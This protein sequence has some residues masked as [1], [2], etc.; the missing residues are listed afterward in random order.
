MSVSLKV[1]TVIPARFA[2]QRL[3][4]KP[5]A[6]ILGKPM[7]QHV[8]ERAAGAR[9]ILM[10]GVATDDARIARAVEGFGGKVW[11]TSPD[12]QS[13]TDR[14]A[15]VARL[16]PEIDIFV[17]V[18]GDEPLMDPAAIGG[19]AVEGVGH[20]HIY[21]DSN[22]IDA[23]A[24]LDYTLLGLTGGPH[25]IEVRLANNDHSELGV[26]DSLTIEMISP[27]IQI[28]APQSGS[29][30]PG[31]SVE[32]QLQIGD[33]TLDPIGS[34]NATGHGHY[35]IEVDGAYYDLGNDPTTAYATRLS[36]GNH[37]V[38]VRLV[39]NDHLPVQEGGTCGTDNLTCS[40]IDVTVPA[41]GPYLALADYG[42]PFGSATVPV[43][44]TVTNFTLD[45]D[46][47]GGT[48]EAGHGHI[49]IYV[50]G[51]YYNY[52]S[53]TSD[54]IY[55]LPAGEHTIK[56]VL[57]NNDHAE[58]GIVDYR[59][60][61]VSATATDVTITSP[62]NNEVVTSTFYT[63]V[64]VSNFTFVDP[65]TNTTN[66]AGE[67][68]YHLYLDGLYYGFSYAS[69]IQMTGLTPGSHT[70]QVGLTN[71]DHSDL[72]PQTMSA[73]ITVTVQ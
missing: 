48:N 53:L 63:N 66:V 11:M 45:G 18:Q 23:T 49:H 37:T 21:V 62:A 28:L 13:G 42:S 27:S 41:D 47:V 29:P 12:L 59:K 30:V 25:T 4:G 38:T 7:I 73:P 55:S 61:N 64:G 3:P 1:A 52:T 68:H 35:H 51:T 2:A 72:S 46:H 33:F 36:P 20:A 39:G 56:V 44:T 5:L 71:N 65:T 40:S 8:F 70:L 34:P 58:L 43:N 22:Y 32:M 60:V 16:H 19:A 10:T 6:D 50:D 24:D 17:N 69:S 67:G 14:V 31:S 57:A 26:S 9:G 54:W 15:A